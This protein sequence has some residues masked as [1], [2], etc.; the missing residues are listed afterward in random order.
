MPE[1]LLVDEKGNFTDSSH[2]VITLKGINI[3]A[4]SKHPSQPFIP[5]YKSITSEN[6]DQYWDGDNVSFLNRPFTIEEA[7]IHF[8]R[9]KKWGYNTL[10]YIFTWESIEH[11]GPKK[12][13]FEFIEFTVKILKIAKEFNFYIFMDPHQDSW[14]RFSGGSGAPL[15][16]F[17]SVGLNPKNFN[18]T[19]GACIH[20][21]YN[22]K[23][24]PKMLWATNYN[25]M[26]CQV[27]F[28]LFFGGKKF[29][30]KCIIDGINIQDYLQSHFLNACLVLYQRIIDEGDLMDTTVIGFESLNEPSIGMIGLQD[31]SKIP[32]DLKLRL[33]T[34]PTAFQGMKLGM[35]LKETLDDYAF[36]YFGPRKIGKK[37]I[38]PQGEKAWSSIE[39][40]EKYGWIR[41]PGWKLGTCIWAQHGVWD[42]T[43]NKV[44][45]P[46][47]FHKIKTSFDNNITIDIEYFHNHFFL[48]Y[49]NN[50][51]KKIR[52]LS[53]TAFAF[54]Q[55][56]V[57]EIPPD[58][59]EKY[60]DNRCVYCP[61]YYD[62]LSLMMKN[63]SSKFNINTLGILRKQCSILGGIVIG[64][65]N[66]RKCL[67]SQ[68]KEIKK[69]G[70]EHMGNIPCLMTETG[71]PFDMN[72]K[73]A[74]KNG[75][76]YLQIKALDALS[77]ALEG[78]NMNHTYW[79]YSSFSCHDHG[80]LWNDEDFS[81]WS[82][83]DMT[84][85]PINKRIL[86][87]IARRLS[88][89]SK[90]SSFGSFSSKAFTRILQLNKSQDSISYNGDDTRSVSIS[91]NLG[92]KD[93]SSK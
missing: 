6:E 57:L 60:L 39:Y 11:K 19:E 82:P 34:C 38:D 71:M 91:V 84:D 74:Y 18:K 13:D 12:Y 21:F 88:I 1:L 89:D 93:I 5:T 7:P 46:D 2:R 20:N 63:W 79:T 22:D 24:Y 85:E 44:L 47:Y 3:D 66:I 26:V 73:L 23:G 70:L 75:D 52:N 78:S 29:A 67:R 27:M 53:K 40:G 51:F 61:H 58:F 76:Y 55:P 17:L 4:T 28:T 81:F 9:I 25:R 72:K 41:D 35:G 42:I 49:W 32:H 59:K 16:T 62:G 30:P 90:S 64:E 45:I 54:C 33:G 14:S 48:E 87:P 10:R 36:G 65:T 86:K 43:T 56:V 15:W 68:F 69:E 80:D 83:D 37:T 31:I 8:N 77:F 92:D 50:H